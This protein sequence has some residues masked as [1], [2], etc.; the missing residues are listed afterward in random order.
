MRGAI[1]G[2]ICGSIY[3]FNNHKTDKP[4]TIDLLNPL[5]FYTDDTVLTCA[6]GQGFLRSIILHHMMIFILPSIHNPPFFGEVV[7]K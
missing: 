7:K 5:C 1:I 3:E 6:E 2:D 4:E